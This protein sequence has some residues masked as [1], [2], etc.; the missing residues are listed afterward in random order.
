L[1]IFGTVVFLSGIISKLKVKN[2]KYNM[3]NT[4]KERKG[5]WMSL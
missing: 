5:G 4:E 2:K 3:A 1:Y